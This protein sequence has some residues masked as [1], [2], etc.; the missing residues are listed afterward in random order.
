MNI[1]KTMGL[2][3][4]GIPIVGI[5][6]GGITFGINFKTDVDMLKDNVAHQE[7]VNAE[8]AEWF[9]SIPNEYND[10]LV[11]NAI[12]NIYIPDEYDDSEIST[13]LTRLAIDLAALQVAVDS[14]EVG[15][16]SDLQAQVAEL[17]GQLSAL[18]SMDMTS[19]DG[20][21]DLGPLIV[22]IATVEGSMTS[23]KSSIDSVKGDIRIMKSD[24]TTLERQPSSS[25]SQTIEN[26][27]DDSDLRTRISAVERQ[28]NSIPTTTSSGTTVQRV[29]NPFDDS[30]LRS[31][32]SALQTAV[33]V[34]QATP[35]QSYDDSGLWDRIDDI[36][37]ELENINIP[38]VSNNTTDTS[39]LED[40]IYEIKDELSWRIDELEWAASGNT[41]D[42]DMYVDTWMFEDL[43]YEVMNIQ[44]QVWELQELANEYEN[45]QNNNTTS[46]NST[47]TEGRSWDGS[48]NEPYWIQ[49]NH[50]DN[51][52]NHSYTGDYWMDGYWNGEAVW[53]N[54][55]CGIPPWDVCHIYKYNHTSWVLQPSE[56]GNEWL[57][58]SYNDNGQWPWEGSWSGDVTSVVKMD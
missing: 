9:N 22:R 24:I 29:E 18:S 54:W 26:R 32:I 6:I 13:K 57:A 44:E 55:N 25:G 37:W 14:I 15:D 19:D 30:S 49:V 16:T 38:T 3:T 56:P 33:A 2:V 5:L 46:N 50:K 48:W 28:V 12:D 31:D 51:S 7:E 42:D 39:W 10:A 41:T 8:V 58:N 20:S 1:S 34:L 11:W 40:L 45:S 52:T 36:Q 53:T 23:L 35:G 43:Q 47:P 17:A 21:V 27:Y 4:G